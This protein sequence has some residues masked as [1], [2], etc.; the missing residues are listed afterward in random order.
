MKVEFLKI[1]YIE[2]WKNR[3]GYG[4]NEKV[5]RG[6]MDSYMII[7]IGSEM[8]NVLTIVT[9]YKVVNK[10]HNINSEVLKET[11]PGPIK[12]IISCN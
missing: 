9:I 5:K 6:N 3:N 10:K 12:E 8:L 2:F 11:F 4:M 1:K 7:K